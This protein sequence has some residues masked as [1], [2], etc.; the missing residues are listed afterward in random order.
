MLQ[1]S[2]IFDTHPQ[3]QKTDSC[4][5]Q[6]TSNTEGSLGG[7]SR[8]QPSAKERELNA[9]RGIG[10]YQMDLK[11]NEHAHN[12]ASQFYPTDSDLP[13]TYADSETPIK[14][15]ED[16]N[17]REALFGQRQYLDKMPGSFPREEL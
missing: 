17:L 6:I 11:F 2:R 15:T 3:H 13:H 16:S 10:D 7:L 8:I 12:D 9:S 14:A 1:V 5:N 4:P